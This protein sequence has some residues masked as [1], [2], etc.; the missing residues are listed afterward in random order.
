M[1]DFYLRP[2]EE[3][4]DDLPDE[5]PPEEL[6]RLDPDELDPLDEGVY[7]RLSDVLLRLGCETVR[8]LPSLLL[9]EGLET[10]RLL[11]SLLLLVC[12]PLIL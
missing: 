9:R 1:I 3:P 12:P 11:P 5:E 10:V 8:L 4:P 2:P 6:P 7:D